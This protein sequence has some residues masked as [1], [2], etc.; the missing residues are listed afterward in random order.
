M[1]HD[2]GNVGQVVHLLPQLDLVGHMCEELV[3]LDAALPVRVHVL[4]QVLYLV[5]RWKHS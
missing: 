2:K 1:C 4:Q 3:Q 5:V